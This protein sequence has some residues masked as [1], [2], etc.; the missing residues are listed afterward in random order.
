VNEA[1]V[2]LLPRRA[3][4]GAR[5]AAER[6]VDEV[7]EVVGDAVEGEGPVPTVTRVVITRER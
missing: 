6:L 5:G 2:P 7:L 3:E 1:V 4:G